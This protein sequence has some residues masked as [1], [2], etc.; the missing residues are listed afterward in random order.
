MDTANDSVDLECQPR[1]EVQKDDVYTGRVRTYWVDREGVPRVFIGPHWPYFS[2]IVF[3]TLC[4]CA[5]NIQ[6]MFDMAHLNN[7][8][9]WVLCVT[10]IMLVVGVASVVSTFLSNPGVP[11][12]M[13]DPA[14]TREQKR[15]AGIPKNQTKWCH[16]CQ[17]YKDEFQDSH[18]E[19]CQVCVR[20][21]DHHCIFYGKCIARDNLCTFRLTVSLPVLSVALTFAAYTYQI[22]T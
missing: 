16:E 5:I 17:I 7:C 12:E 6:M 15:L 13:F 9:W 3:M 11:R 2:V 19:V 22:L 1:L 21:Y 18:C 20:G 14:L 8:P 4:F 10:S